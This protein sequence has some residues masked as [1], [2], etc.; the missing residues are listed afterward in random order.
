VRLAD[1]VPQLQIVIDHLPHMEQPVAAEDKQAV[2]TYL[3]EP[4]AAPKVSIKLSEIPQLANGSL[5]RDITFY[6]Q[7]LDTLWTLFGEDR[8]LFGSDWP[9]SD[10][11]ASLHQTVSLVKK[12]MAEKSP[13]GRRKFFSENCQRI[14]GCKPRDANG[15]AQVPIARKL[16]PS[17]PS[18]RCLPDI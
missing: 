16:I 1:R 15:Q 12:Y 11:V 2:A 5:R 7:H 10:H 17:S 3:R 8:C 6:Q 14:Y 13:T 4:A 18:R 9:N